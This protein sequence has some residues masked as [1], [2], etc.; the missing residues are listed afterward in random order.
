MTDT[1]L[2]FDF[3]YQEAYTSN[4]E[5]DTQINEKHRGKEQ[6]YPKWTYPKRIFTLKFD[7]NF[8]GRQELENFFINSMQSGGKFYWTWE[9]SKGGNDKTYICH[10]E[11]EKFKQNI[12][13]LGYTECELGLVCID[14]NAVTPPEKFNFYHDSE[15]DNSLE[16]YRIMDNLFTAANNIKVWWDSPKKSW[17]LKFDKDPIARKQIE[18]FFI[19]KRGR[20]RSFD[21]TW[22]KSKGG[23]DKTYHVRFD[24]DNLQMD[25]DKY[26]YANF[27]VQ[28]KEVFSTTNPLLE[29]E[30]DEIIPRKLL[31]IDIPGGGIRIIDNETLAALT[32][33][34]E[35]YLGAP[36]T[37]GEITKNDNSSVS[38]LNISLS[39]VGLGISGIIGTRGD[40][41]TNAAA[42]LMLVFLDVNTNTLIPGLQQILYAGKCN[43]VNLDYEL[44]TMDIET[45]L[46]G[47]EKQCPA[48][49][50]RASCQVRRFKDCR[51]GYTGTE[52]SCDRTFARCKELKNQANFRGFPTM[53]E[54]LVV[55]V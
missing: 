15:C 32:F 37:H 36:L 52:T 42:V 14:S 46:G 24:S 17:T 31:N 34:G 27:Q 2:T 47:Y 30:K 8:T 26:G 16:Y 9:K 45:P 6:R 7:K 11:S 4:I 50:Y 3:E 49:K 19:A 23:D 41:V 40:V 38:K 33:N 25:M 39:N 5:F 10:F 28:L 12:K 44:A 35:E 21:W 29:V 22:E 18:D 1:L 13:N 48:M 43:N 51:C 55:K 54:E 20:F 53:Y